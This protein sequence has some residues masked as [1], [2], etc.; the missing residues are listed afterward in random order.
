MSRSNVINSKQH[1]LSL[2]VQQ[3]D[4]ELRETGKGSRPVKMLKSFF[5][6]GSP[7]ISELSRRNDASRAAIRSWSSSIALEWLEAQERMLV[8]RAEQIAEL[9]ENGQPLLAT[10][11]KVKHDSALFRCTLDHVIN[12]KAGTL[13]GVPCLSV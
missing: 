2:A 3:K 7:T 8:D 13:S 4:S 9:V 12:V 5:A 6:V 1:R 10:F 11:H